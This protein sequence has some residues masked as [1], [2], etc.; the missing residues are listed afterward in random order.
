MTRNLSI[1]IGV[2]IAL[3]TSSVLATQCRCLP[4]QACWPNKA[5]WD[6]LGKQLHGK[7]I[8]PTPELAACQ[9]DANSAACKASLTALH[10]P[11][12]IENNPGATQSTGWMNAWQTAA[13]P[14]A[15]AAA[16]A[17][18]V[19]AAVNF[20]HKYH[21]RVVIKGTGHDYLGRSNAPNSL[22]IWTHNMRTIQY[23]E[24]FIPSGCNSKMKGIPAL[25]VG[26]GTR[27]LE[28]YDAAV[29]QHNRYIQGGGCTTVGA[30]GGFI[31]GGGF[32]SFSKKYGT[33]AA[34]LLQAEIVTADGKTIIANQCQYKDLFWAIRGGGGS[35]YGVVTKV[36]LKTHNLPANFG[37]LFGTIKAKN[38]SAYK[39]LIKEILTLYY[40]DLN[41]EHWGEQIRFST[42]NTVNFGMTFVNLN[43]EQITYAFAPLVTWISEHKKDYQMNLKPSIIPANKLWN[44]DY[45]KT[46]HPALFTLNN[47]PDALPNQ[48]WWTTNTAEVSSYW[49]TY[50]S[51]WLP[52]QLFDDKHVAQLTNA[53][54]EASRLSAVNLHFNKGLAGASNEAINATKNTSTNPEVLNAAAL[55]IMAARTNENYPGVKGKTPNLEQGKAAQDKITRAM[56]Y[57]IKLAPQAGAYV[58]EADYFMPNW[59]KAFWGSHYNLLLGI[60]NKY[61]PDGLFYCHHCVGS[62]KWSEDGMCSI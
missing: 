50:Q 9:H 33:G 52:S 12:Q 20:A 1:L 2:M 59:Q 6:S 34:G 57:F 10:N 38:D 47:A 62:E 32:G 21:L 3:Y 29:N 22:L 45:L 49:Y 26:A 56:Q 30:A 15:V 46:A 48:F 53:I 44:L 4:N 31:Q 42:D 51:W 7:L 39:A 37:L 54:Y 41:N 28:A 17:D 8:T 18:D 14:Y 36:T 11:F 58:N 61:D 13:S 40:R 35:T 55:V 16:D 24:K 27:W 25:T 5:A 19:A 43:I 60:K 23:E